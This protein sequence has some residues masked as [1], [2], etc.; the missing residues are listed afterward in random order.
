MAMC[1]LGIVQL[2]LV[3]KVGFGY[4]LFV[5][6]FVVEVAELIDVINSGIK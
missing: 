4:I 5:Y 6:V 3:I 1:L 2:D